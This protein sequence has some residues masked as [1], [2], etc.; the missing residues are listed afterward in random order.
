MFIE[1]YINDFDERLY[2]DYLRN[3]NK[4]RQLADAYIHQFDN[5]TYDCT[6]AFKESLDHYVAK[7]YLNNPTF[8][9]DEKFIFPPLIAFPCNIF[10][11]KEFQW[12]TINWNI[13]PI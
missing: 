1:K 5:P 12:E 8:I 3:P 4:L 10:F 2:I 9:N 7:Q 6:I 11:Q 13:I